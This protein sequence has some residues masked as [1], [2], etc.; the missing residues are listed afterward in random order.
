MK[1]K[2]KPK[3]LCK[4]FLKLPLTQS[5]ALFRETNVVIKSS[6]NFININ[7]FVFQITTYYAQQ[8]EQQLI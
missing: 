1:T 4:C 8:Y 3:S 7:V 5:A 6:V 2:E